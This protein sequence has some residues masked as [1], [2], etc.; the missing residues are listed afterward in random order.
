MFILAEETE[1]GLHRLRYEAIRLLGKAGDTYMSHSRKK[2]DLTGQRYGQ[3]TVLAPAENIGSRTAWLCRCDCGKETVVKTHHLR[4][5]HTKSCGCQNG[6]GGP[7]YALGLT[8]I[9]GTCVEMIRA[10]TLR[11]NNT[12]GVQ[13]VDWLAKKQRWRATICF[14]GKRR[15]LG[16]Y[17]KFEDAVKARK[18]AEEAVF[19][20]FLDACSGETIQ[21]GP[22]DIEEICPPIARDYNSQKLD[23]VGQRFGRLTVLEPAE[24][25][26]AMTAWRCRCDCGKETVVMTAHLRSGQTT[27]CGC[28]PKGTFVD[29][30]FVELLRAK[31]L[32]SNNTSGVTG[33]EWVPAT[34]MWRAVIF[35]KGKRHYLGSY[36]KFEDAVKAR[37]RGEEEY[38]DKFLEEFAAG[39]TDEDN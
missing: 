5:G 34:S 37:K 13:G 32:R 30:T 14:K 10:N 16:S 15:Y 26:G 24:N 9:D 7:R 23:L 22:K 33:V 36:G 1:G 19:G 20:V 2:L 29:G 6:E 28:K 18:R 38:H 31:T 8:Y 3:L 12:S 39:R 4:S 35:F 27:S 17:E 21:G 25:I 11:S